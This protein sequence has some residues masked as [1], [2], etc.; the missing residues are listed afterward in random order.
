MPDFRL[1]LEELMLTVFPLAVL[2][3]LNSSVS[4]KFNFE[5]LTMRVGLLYHFPSF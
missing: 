5:L 2:K 4:R 1:I 3:N